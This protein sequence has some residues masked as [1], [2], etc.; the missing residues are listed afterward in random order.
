M[1]EKAAQR[2]AVVAGATGLVGSEL[3][4]RLLAQRAYRRIVALSRRPLD[5]NP[6]LEVVEAA[7][8]QLHRVLDPATR[9]SEPIDVFCCLGTTIRS[10]GSHEA[11]RRVDRD[12]VVALGRWARDADARR[13]V[14]VSAAGADASSRVFYNRV[15]GEM[16]RELAALGL[17]SL[18]IARPSL[19][20]GERDEFRPA[21]RVALALTRPMRALL[22]A[23]VRPIAAADVAQAMIDAALAFDPPRTLDSAAMQ[24]AAS[25]A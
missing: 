18:V 3:V 4:R 5:P 6:R 22:P 23:T 7:Y 24:G 25:R 11:F 17:P 1:T 13:F 9:R 21:E 2:I 8:D 14:V 10:A 12:Y 19:L 15:K 16:E 20:A